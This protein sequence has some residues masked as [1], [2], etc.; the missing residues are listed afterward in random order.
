VEDEVEEGT[1]H[2][3]LSVTIATND[4]STEFA[5]VSAEG[6]PGHPYTI[7]WAAA[8]H[9][10]GPLAYD[11][12]MEQATTLGG[13]LGPGDPSEQ[14]LRVWRH[15]ATRRDVE[16]IRRRL[17]V[18]RE[19]EAYDY[20]KAPKLLHEL[21]RMPETVR[22]IG[23]WKPYG[24]RQENPTSAPLVLW[25]GGR[26]WVGPVEILPGSPKDQQ[27]GPGIYL[28]T[29]ASTAR[30]YARG[31]GVVMRVEVEQPLRWLDDARVRLADAKAWAK[32]EPGL[33]HRREILADLDRNAARTVGDTILAE[34]LVNLCVNYE[35]L[36]GEHGPSLARW[37]VA[38][39]IDAYAF[40]PPLFTTDESNED[41]VVIF[42]PEKILSRRRATPAEVVDQPRLLPRKRSRNPVAKKRAKKKA[43]GPLKLA[44]E[45]AGYLN[46][47]VDPYDFGWLLTD[48][49][50]ALEDVQVDELSDEDRAA[51]TAWLRE[52]RY[53]RGSVHGSPV[54]E[55]MRGDP[56]GVPSY[57]YFRDA[58]PLGEGAWC[59]HFTARAFSTFKQG[60]TIEMLGLSTHYQ[61]KAQVSCE[62][63]LDEEI[64]LFERVYGFA[65]S[66]D[67]LTR[68]GH[69]R[70]ARKKYGFSAILFQTD[71]GVSAY[72]VSDDEQQVVF[73]LCSEWNEHEIT[74]ENG[75]SEVW[76]TRPGEDDLPFKSLEAVTA[77]LEAEAAAP[78]RRANP[79]YRALP[80]AEVRRWRPVAARQ[81]VSEVARG[82]GGFLPAYEAAKGQLDRLSPWWRA[83]REAFLKRHLAQVKLHHEP[84]FTAK[85]EP[86]RRHLAL[87]MWAYSPS[88]TALGGRR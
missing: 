33:R 40:K 77:Y 42:N 3:V 60:A 15:Y 2:N 69:I 17:S 9:G 21:A 67:Q 81:G 38:Q 27:H 63:N 11:I 50:P 49:N 41:W 62:R 43:L 88:P 46:I 44:E 83:R 54:D 8:Q 20:R 22:Y 84:L 1:S 58:R 35:V 82:P 12:M 36:S 70:Q 30:R 80:L 73:P 86:T 78:R 31:G 52:P 65:F 59:V 39:G 75:S 85:G 23:E 87:I 45:L 53:T 7:S 47:E 66:V 74:F 24:A 68:A 32:N 13:T 14:A 79:A 48:W 64:G 71:A 28:T 18:L 61:E 5:H 19:E 76:L 4:H 6:A 37:L 51:F 72:H 26:P 16:K 34:V 10:W 56:L 29:G 25:H 57:L 55:A